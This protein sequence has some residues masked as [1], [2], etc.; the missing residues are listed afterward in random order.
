MEYGWGDDF[1]FAGG[2]QLTDLPMEPAPPENAP[3]PG[4]VVLGRFQPV[5][6]GHALMIEAANAWR[7]S[8]A[9]NDPLIIAIGSSNRPESIRNPW[10]SEERR[11]ML[12]GWLS[13]EGISAQL[14]EIPDIEDPPNWVPHSERYHGGPGVFFTTDMES[15]ELY[16]SSGWEVV[17]TELERREIFEGWRVRATAQMMSTVQDSEAVRTVLGASIPDAV[18]SHLLE[19]DLIRR[20]AFLG[21]GGEPVG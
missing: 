21:E 9:P 8:N 11:S 3:G 17:M 16:E 1:G 13:S 14:V 7:S 19:N 12:E 18:V 2:E 6:R 15:A 10:S 4:V 5:H 20:L